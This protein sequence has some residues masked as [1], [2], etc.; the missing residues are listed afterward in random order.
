MRNAL[1]DR[2]VE[3]RPDWLTAAL[4]DRP[5]AGRDAQTWEKSARALASFRLD[6]DVSDDRTPLGP[7]PPASDDHRRAWENAI[8]DLHRAQRLLGREPADR[9]QSLDLGIG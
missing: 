2:D 9:S 8:A 3:G 4:G 6:H 7:E 5:P 1:A